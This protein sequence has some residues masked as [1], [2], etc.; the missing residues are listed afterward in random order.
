MK[1]KKENN[2]EKVTKTSNM[3]DVVFKYPEAVEILLEYGLHCVGCAFAAA[4]SIE[5][6][7][8]V[9]GIADEDIDEMVERINKVIK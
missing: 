2:K 7:A 8:K 1:N 3:A 4:D 5:E 6:G 9:H